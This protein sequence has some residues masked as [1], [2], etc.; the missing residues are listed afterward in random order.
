MNYMLE[1]CGEVERLWLQ[2]P[3][4]SSSGWADGEVEKSLEAVKE[5]VR[6]GGRTGR[7][8]GFVVR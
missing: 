3:G 4:D 1:K 5:Q 8:E 2:G 6:E 7:A